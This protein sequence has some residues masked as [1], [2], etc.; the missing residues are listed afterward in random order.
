[1]FFPILLIKISSYFPFQSP[2]VQGT[3]DNW[4]D[5][6]SE[7]AENSVC[8]IM[9]IQKRSPR[10]KAIFADFQEAANKTA[11]LIKF[12]SLDIKEHP[13]VAYLYTVRTA[14]A[15]RIVHPKG[16]IEYKS[17]KTADAFIEA[18][19]KYFPMKSKAIDETWFPSPST[20]LSAI[21][22]T[23]KKVTPKFWAAL[24]CNLT[25]NKDLNIR[26]G[27][28]KNSQFMSQFQVSSQSIIFVYKDIASIY[29]GPLEFANIYS[30][31]LK[32]IKDP[33]STGVETSVVTEQKTLNEFETNC[34][35]T[36]K[37]CVF[38]VNSNQ[39]ELKEYETTAKTYH[40]GPFRFLKCHEQCPL[41]IMDHG[42]IVFHAKR[43]QMI[44]V[45]TIPDLI[46]TLD[47]VVDGGATWKKINDQKEL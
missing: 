12:V 24:S 29:E 10:S 41:D 15:F 21:L 17:E 31:L 6:V 2:V 18:A 39:N 13:K 36:G 45:E 37:F 3:T 42:F 1:M 25:N 34:M 11:G 14:P 22:L 20:P 30:S 4:V 7:Y 44:Q 33:K 40:R 5:E 8:F 28:A 47:R 46:A 23:P 27:H 32:F 16:V 35:N 19:F 38:A 26:I 9:F 43:P